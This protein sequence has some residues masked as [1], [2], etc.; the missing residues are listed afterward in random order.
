[1]AVSLTGALHC[2]GAAPP[3]DPPPEMS[4]TMSF[5]VKEATLAGGAVAVHAEIPLPAAGRRPAVIALL[6]NRRALRAAGFVV[7]TYSVRWERVPGRL[8]TPAPGQP[9]VGTWVLASPSAARLGEGYL[10]DIAVTAERF[11]PAVLDWLVG[12][13]EVDGERLA[14]VGGSTNGF[15]ALQ[16]AAVDPRLRAVV[17]ISAC[18]DYPAF[19]QGSGM[20]LGGAPLELAPDYTAWIAEQQVISHP[21][22][23]LHAAVL[24]INRAA[25]PLIPVACADETARVLAAAYAAAGQAERFRYDRLDAQGHG[26]DAAENAAAME[27]LTRWLRPG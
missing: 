24:M 23:L 17:A 20:G 9:T 5:L 2:R 19:L 12:L 14:M 13:P 7:V 26:V 6:G 3:A 22:R 16:A 11:V 18:G 25:D 1:M 15:V 8:P 10:R 27:W 4:D 21:D